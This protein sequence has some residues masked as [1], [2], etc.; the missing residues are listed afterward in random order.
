VRQG[1]GTGKQLHELVAGWA[2]R[3]LLGKY[4]FIATYLG[5]VLTLAIGFLGH[6]LGFVIL[7]RSLPSSDIGQL[8][9]MTAASS[10]GAVWC[11][12][13]VSE[14]A[15]RRVGRDQAEYPRVL[16]HSLILIFGVGA[17]ISLI[18]VLLVAYFLHL[19]SSF[20]RSVEVAAL[21]VPCNVVLFVFIGFAEQ[22]VN[23]RGNLR[24]ANYINA[25][26]GLARAVV[27]VIACFA[28]GVSN[29]AE[30]APWHFAFY[31][32]VSLGC[33]MCIW[34]YG[35]PHWTIMRDEL[36]RGATMSIWGCLHAL[37][38]NI[39]MFA[40]SAVAT[41]AFVGNYSVARRVLGAAAMVGQGLDRVV[42]SRLVV[43]G[44]GGVR[45]TTTLVKRYAAYLTGPLIAASI[46][47]FIAAAYIPFVFG[48]KYGDAVH[49]VRVLCSII[50]AWGLQ[51]LA[52]DALN[53]S[54]QHFVRLV[55]SVVAACVGCA[56]IGAG[57]YLY[58]VNGTLCGVVAAE[59]LIAGALW[60]A[61]LKLARRA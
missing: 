42:Y 27:T 14:M 60:I 61:L 22:I 39:D 29:L 37:R 18:L 12:L 9:M 16:G 2:P 7:A 11:E 51:N 3:A 36:T 1:T 30:W 35:A 17:L 45:V 49:I 54:E 25:G 5:S 8:A 19:A 26:H 20:Y 50:V 48:A 44:R 13:G 40:L 28:F 34:G 6:T 10:L 58:G 38:Q 32:I 15:R 23:A 56:L 31:S 47:A 52:F 4:Q 57:T 55:V 53:A 59:H 21:V 41:P 43:V 46:A 33:L 24:Y